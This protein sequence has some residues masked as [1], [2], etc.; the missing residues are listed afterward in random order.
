[1]NPPA[2]AAPAGAPNEDA[3]GA[4]AAFAELA[5]AP[6]NENTAGGAPPAGG[7]GGVGGSDIRST[8]LGK[9]YTWFKPRAKRYGSAR[10]GIR[11]RN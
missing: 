4:A 10:G 7:F 2:G 11:T 6:P 9:S 3:A 1:M 8:A 5:E